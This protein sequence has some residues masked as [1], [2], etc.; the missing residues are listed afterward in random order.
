MLRGHDI[1]CISSI[2]WSEHWQ[3]HHELMTRLAAARQPRAV[4]RKHRRAARRASPTFRRVRRRVGELVAQHA[5]VSATNARTCSCYSPLFLPFPY[6][7]VAGWINRVLL[8]RGLRRWMQATGFT[9]PIVVDVPADAACAEPHRRGLAQGRR[10][11]TAPTISRS[12]SAVGPPHRDERAAADQGSRPRVRHLRAAARARRGAR[13]P[14][15]S[16]SRRRRLR[17]S[18]TRCAT[19]TRRCRARRSRARCRGRWSATSARFIR[20]SI[21]LLIAKLAARLPD[22]SF[23]LVGPAYEPMC[24]RLEACRQRAS[25][26]P[27]SAQR[28]A[29]LHQG[30]R[31]RPRARIASA[32]TRPACIR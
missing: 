20:G 27:A 2:D 5:R 31:R 25:A 11:T 21:R 7:R 15:P 10:S 32:N 28:R 29:A 13:R 9:R 4:H 30:L 14:G 24:R 22:V 3:I 16:L 26:R 19:A 17:R 23:A 8:F 18:S 12:S 1:L 6:S